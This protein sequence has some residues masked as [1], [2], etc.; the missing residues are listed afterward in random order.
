MSRLGLVLCGLLV[1]SIHLTQILDPWRISGDARQHVFWTYRFAD[2][3]LFEDDLLVDF[4]S[5]PRFDPPGYVAVYAIG[6]RWIDALLFSKLLA[7]VLAFG[8]GWFAFR[9]G[10]K[11]AG[12]VAGVLAV[13]AFGFLC[14]DDIRGGIPR[15]F[16]FPILLLFTD[17]LLHRRGWVCGAAFMAASLFYPPLVIS[18]G[19]VLPLLLLDGGRVVWSRIGR[20]V[21]PLGVP[22]ALAACVVGYSFLAADAELTGP[23]VTRDAAFSMPEFQEGG[24]NEFWIEDQVAFWIGDW[25]YNRSSCGLLS[26]NVFFPLAAC[27]LLLAV[28]RRRFR[29]PMELGWMAATS[30]LLFFVAHAILFT[31][32]LPSRYTLYTWP[33]A[34]TCIAVSN[35]APLIEPLG[36]P[37]LTRANGRVGLLAAVVVGVVLVTIIATGDRKTPPRWK[38]DLLAAV[39]ALPKSAVIAGEPESLDDIPLFTRRKVFVN[40]ELSLAYYTAYYAR[41]RERVRISAALLASS[42]ESRRQEIARRHGITHL[43]RVAPSGEWSLEDLRTR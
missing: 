6:A 23:M 40:R 24:R 5:S 16:A 13:L 31:I 15:S 27:V 28:R 3:E 36:F 35:A 1:V 10:R 39:E 4:I 17:G 7:A 12:E 29:L 33:I 22:I 38:L 30:L 21:L 2:A 34:F 41:V 9:I 42:S 26:S 8:A 43:L 32:F 25:G 14:F 20:L 19:V 11:L 18:M 37:W